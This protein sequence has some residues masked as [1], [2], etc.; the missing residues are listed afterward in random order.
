MSQ[1]S[2]TINRATDRVRSTL[3]T[4]AFQQLTPWADWVVAEPSRESAARERA[5]NARPRR[6]S[7]LIRRALAAADVT[8]LTIAFVIGQLFIAENPAAVD[9]VGLLQETLVFV[10]TLPAWVL[11]ARAYGLYDR[12]EEQANYSSVDDTWGVLNMVTLGTWILVAGTWL[13]HVADPNFRKLFAFWVSAILLVSLW[14]HRRPR[15]RSTDRRRTSR[16]R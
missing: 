7:W 8:G 1:A 10:A 12:D 2:D 14:P 15:A 5:T 13:T 4:D 16:T 9:R 11:L 3:S 6:R